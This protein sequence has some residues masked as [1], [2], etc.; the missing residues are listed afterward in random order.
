LV[1]APEAEAPLSGP[2][3][4]L[5]RALAAVREATAAFEA[6]DEPV[7]QLQGVIGDADR[8]ATELAA[9]QAERQQRIGQWLADGQEG[10]RP[11]AT[12]EEARAEEAARRARSD[13][14]AAGL[15]LLPLLAQRNLF[16]SRVNAVAADRDAAWCRRRAA[17]RPAQIGTI[18]APIAIN[19][20]DPRIR[21]QVPR[22]A[23]GT[24][25]PYRVDVGNLSLSASALGRS[26]TAGDR[27]RF[28][29]A[30]VRTHLPVMMDYFELVDGELDHRAVV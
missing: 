28:R 20:R 22:V 8:L 30:Q 7:R 12:E 18:S 3:E 13:A 15:A 17:P 26:E 1:A 2:R 6:A 23:H 14:E 10:E 9:L 4:E 5:K 11:P 29:S 27:H 19:R 25:N 21:A 16:L 24:A